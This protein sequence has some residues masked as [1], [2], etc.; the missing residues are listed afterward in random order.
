MQCLGRWML[1]NRCQRYHCSH[2]HEPIE[3]EV[4]DLSYCET[5]ASKQSSCV[6]DSRN[7]LTLWWPCWVSGFRG[8]RRY[9]G[10]PLSVA[11]NE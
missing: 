4:S 2:A 1:C 5:E 6:V 8:E 9:S 11:G 7:C 3:V 10:C